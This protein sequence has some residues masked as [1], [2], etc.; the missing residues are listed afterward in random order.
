L[1]HCH[2]SVLTAALL[3]MSLRPPLP[4]PHTTLLPNDRTHIACSAADRE[5]AAA[6]ASRMFLATADAAA[7]RVFTCTTGGMCTMRSQVLTAGLRM[8]SVLLLR[9]QLLLARMPSVSSEEDP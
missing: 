9:L 5:G 3:L 7:T 6:V 1:K 8:P 4:M 2:Q